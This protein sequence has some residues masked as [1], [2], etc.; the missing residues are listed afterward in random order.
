MAHTAFGH[1]K[2]AWQTSAR[3]PKGWRRDLGM[4]TRIAAVQAADWARDAERMRLQ[5]HPGAK[6]MAEA[7]SEQ[8]HSARQA[9]NAL[10]ETDRDRR[11]SYRRSAHDAGERA[12]RMMREAQ[13]SYGPPSVLAVLRDMFPQQPYEAEPVPQVNL[14]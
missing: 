1:T 14:G 8:L 11:D 4:A 2:E 13:R 9:I 10:S 3:E 6:R 7:A 5:G 12:Y